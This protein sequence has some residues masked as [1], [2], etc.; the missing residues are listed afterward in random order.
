MK[1]MLTVVAILAVLM[2]CGGDKTEVKGGDGATVTKLDVK[3]KANP[4]GPG[5]WTYE[6]LASVTQTL[7]RL[8]PG[9]YEVGAN[10]SEEYPDRA[11]R[12]KVDIGE[13][14]VGNVPITNV[15]YYLFVNDRKGYED[16]AFW[17]EEGWKWRQENN[18]TAPEG[19]DKIKD[20]IVP[21]SEAEANN[22]PA[23]GVSYYEAEAFAKSMGCVK[24]HKNEACNYKNKT[25]ADGKPIRLPTEFEFEVG[26]SLRGAPM[27]SVDKPCD[28]QSDR[29]PGNNPVNPVDVRVPGR[30]VKTAVIAFGASP[31]VGM[32]DV[33]GN[34]L[35]WTQS[36][37]KPYPGSTFQ[38][39]APYQGWI[40]ARGSDYASNDALK[41]LTSRTPLDKRTRD[42][43]VGFRLAVEDPTYVDCI[44]SDIRI[45]CKLD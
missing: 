35:Q 42:E 16:K 25:Y 11:P 43:R 27:Q 33:K 9:Q 7:R 17:S 41:E 24:G 32:V 10:R 23:T 26:S 14:R 6:Q 15:L 4:L 21:G 40:V 22:F 39:P 2:A 31:C 12:H 19:W 38:I 45:N 34:I 36:E 20:Q 3:T 44:W 30:K 18:I 28:G 37:Y 29:Y 5:G 1:A 8:P 13:V